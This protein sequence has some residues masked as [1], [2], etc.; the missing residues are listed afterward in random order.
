MTDLPVLQSLLERV[1]GATGADREIDSRLNRLA[2]G[3]TPVLWPKGSRSKPYTASLDAALA[4][5]ERVLPGHLI[6]LAGPWRYADH[7][8]KAGQ[9]IWNAELHED[10]E[11]VCVTDLE[12][13]GAT[14]ALA[15]IAA[16]LHAKIAELQKGMTNG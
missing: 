1:E 8:P 6:A 15:A 12:A 2:Y 7:H 3:D 5:V 14:P 10:F 16:L 13:R 4:L 9:P 11:A